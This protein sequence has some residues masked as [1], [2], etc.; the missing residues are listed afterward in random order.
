MFSRF[1]HHLYAEL[2]WYSLVSCGLSGEMCTWLRMRSGFL[3]DRACIEFIVKS[4]LLGL[5]ITTWWR[6]RHLSWICICELFDS[7]RISPRQVKL[8]REYLRVARR[9][10]APKEELM[11]ACKLIQE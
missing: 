5:L 8:P 3:G 4:R 9:N 7:Y 11:K 1:S 2:T 10:K 6:K